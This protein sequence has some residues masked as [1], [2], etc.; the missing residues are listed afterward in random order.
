MAKS[1]YR[2]GSKTVSKNP[3]PKSN[4][5]GHDCGIIRLSGEINGVRY[6]FGVRNPFS[7]RNPA[8]LDERHLPALRA[9]LGFV[10]PG[11]L[12]KR[13][14]ISEVEFNRRCPAEH[15]WSLLVG[16]L[17]CWVRTS[18]VSTT[19]DSHFASPSFQENLDG[20][21]RIAYVRFSE[22]VIPI[23]KA[24]LESSDTVT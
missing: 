10:D 16:I 19:V 20:T 4:R 1:A 24:M 3:K 7:R 22:D 8:P 2:P 21:E 13:F 11:D 9:L 18:T 12:E 5:G 23:L 17:T 14:A 6:R 15:A